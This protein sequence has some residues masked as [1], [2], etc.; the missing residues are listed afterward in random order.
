ML[1]APLYAALSYTTYNQVCVDTSKGRKTMEKLGTTLVKVVALTGGA[2]LG[3][4]LARWCDE[5]MNT[6]SKER[7]EQDRTRYEQGLGP[8]APQPPLEKQG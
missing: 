1:D 2:F 3:A 4:L 5:L 6:R 8:I 7:S